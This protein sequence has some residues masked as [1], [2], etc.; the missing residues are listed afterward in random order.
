MTTPAKD[1]IQRAQIELQDVVGV[2]WPATELV[3]YMKD[4]ERSIAVKRPD[5][6]AVEA[7]QTLVAGERQTMPA[8]AASLID[9]TRN[10]S[11]F[12]KK[13][14]TRTSQFVIEAVEPNW[15]TQTQSGEVV[16]FCY[17][18]REPRTYL[19]Y[20]PAIAGTQV[21]MIYSAYPVPDYEAAGAAF[22]TVTGDITLADEWADAL[23]YYILYRAWSKD[24]ESGGNSTLAG[25]NYQLF[26]AELGEQI[27]GSSAVSPKE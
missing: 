20:P 12:S 23:R 27:E 26:K 16:H 8:A 9:I 4:G 17:D 24:S 25:Q 22:G 15:R 3:L 1:I 7:T 21:Q 18:M 5:Q 14:I 13:A 19:V 2:R 6:T 11:Q 10:N